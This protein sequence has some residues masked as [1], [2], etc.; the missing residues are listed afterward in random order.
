MITIA[1]VLR[2][3]GDYDTLDVEKLMDGLWGNLYLPYRFVCFT[4]LP[5]QMF[6]MG[7]IPVPLWNDWPGWWSKMNLFSAAV[8]GDILFLDLDTIISGDLNDLAQFNRIGIM[9]DV[10]RPDGQQSSVMF[11]P[12]QEKKP[13]WDAFCTDPDGHM[14]RQGVRGDQGFLETLWLERAARF[15]DHLPGQLVSYKADNVATKGV[16]ENARAVIFHGQPRPRS[17]NWT[18]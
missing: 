15:Q 18:L 6:P 12:E 5:P 11:I 17:I 10:Y 13:V 9:R 7:C 8:E 1:C 14:N 16:P 3:G 4:D 2:S